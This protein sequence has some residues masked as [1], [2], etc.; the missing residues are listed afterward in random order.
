[1][2]HVSTITSKGQVTIPAVIRR[3]LGLKPHDKVA[4]HLE[5]DV[6]RIEPAK[7]SV[8]DNYGAVKLR[9][10]TKNLKRL[11]RETEEWVAEQAMREL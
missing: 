11:R 10:S 5:D 2:K 6:V 8:L 9:G 4:F 7:M 3:A 1:M